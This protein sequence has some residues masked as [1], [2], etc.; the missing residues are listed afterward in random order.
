MHNYLKKVLALMA[1]GVIKT[2]GTDAAFN[3]HTH[4]AHDDWCGIYSRR[5]CNCDP[6]V[7]VS[8]SADSKQ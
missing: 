6:I 7:T 1:S 3:Q 5:E 4:I 8:Q 2:D